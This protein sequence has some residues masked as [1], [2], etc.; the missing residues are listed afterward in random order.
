V[1]IISKPSVETFLGMKRKG[2]K[3]DT[4]CG[5]IEDLAKDLYIW[6]DHH[7]KHSIDSS[8]STRFMNRGMWRIA[9]HCY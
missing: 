4:C 3:G 6:T 9:D 8:N 1:N 2:T 5:P 7:W